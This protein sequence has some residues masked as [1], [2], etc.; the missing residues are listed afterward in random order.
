MPLLGGGLAKLLVLLRR[1]GDVVRQS[2]DPRHLRLGIFLVHDNL[3]GGVIQAALAGAVEVGR[4]IRLQRRGGSRVLAA[5]DG[6][7]IGAARAVDKAG[8]GDGAVAGGAVV[9]GAGVAGS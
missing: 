7:G 8:R 1:D 2:A 4:R 3:H 5:G 6:R 9:V